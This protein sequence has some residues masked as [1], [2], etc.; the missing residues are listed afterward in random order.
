MAH[1][2]QLDDSNVVLHVNVIADA[3]C[4]D[5]DG[6]ESEAVGIAFCQSLWGADNTWKQTSFNENMR[7]NFAQVGST[8]DASR[9]AFLEIKQGNIA[10][11]V[12]NDT[13][14]KWEAPV[15]KP[16]DGKLY[17]WDEDTISWVELDVPDEY[18]EAGD[19]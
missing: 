14:C 7:K 12:L 5:G 19:I 18:K 1:F 6:N 17:G 16:D 9:D 10:S 15:E 8:Y 11:W 2:A 4:L 3:D 13:T